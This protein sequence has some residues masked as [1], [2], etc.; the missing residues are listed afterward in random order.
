MTRTN[1]GWFQKGH[2]P[3]RHRFTSATARVAGSKPTCYRLTRADRVKGG[4]AAWALMMAEVRLSLGLDLPTERV[5]EAARKLLARRRAAGTMSQV[6]PRY[7][8]A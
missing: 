2:D 6:H 1:K 3:R 7:R 4:L 5:R 8:T